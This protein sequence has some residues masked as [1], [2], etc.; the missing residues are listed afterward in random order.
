MNNRRRFLSIAA[1]VLLP[2]FSFAQAPPAAAPVSASGAQGRGGGRGRGGAAVV[3]P[4]TAADGRV[5]FR[6]RAPDA[7]AVSVTGIGTAA[8]LMTKDAQGV[9]SATT[10]DALKPDIYSYAFIVDGA[11]VPD[12]ANLGSGWITYHDSTLLVPGVPWTNNSSDLPHGAVAKHIYKSAIIGGPET[13]YVYTPPAYD[14]K[15]AKP[16]PVLVLLHGLGAT[17]QAA[18]EWIGQG[19]ANLI[20]DSLIAE[21]KAEPMILVTPGANGNIQGTRGA[22]AGFPNFTKALIEEILP[23]VEKEYNAS[24]KASDHAISGLSAGAAQSPLLLNRL[25]QFQWIGSF[26]PGFDM[27]N[28]AWGTSGMGPTVNGQRALLPAGTYESTFPNLDSKANS[29]IKLLYVACGTADDHLALTRQFKAFLD[30]RKVRVTYVE[31]LNDTHSYSFWRPQLTAF[32]AM[33]FKPR[34][35]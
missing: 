7:T 24:D 11:R 4:E 17:P 27:Y 23:Q 19:G 6:F 29:Q 2:A 33:I 31:G 28:P 26:S 30:E 3:S 34:A 14:V 35:K 12:P 25:D 9:W 8:L 5:T 13:Y 10:A 21:G 20:L 32:A 1:A 18:Q 16:Y 22:A 15:R